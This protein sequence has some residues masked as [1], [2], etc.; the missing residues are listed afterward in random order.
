MDQVGSESKCSGRLTTKFVGPD[1]AALATKRKYSHDMSAI[2][3]VDVLSPGG[4]RTWTNDIVS[5]DAGM[6]SARHRSC[7][8]SPGMSRGRDQPFYGMPSVTRGDSR[9]SA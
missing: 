3:V 2:P 9:T 8:I 4:A 5:E 6:K 7:V 1:M